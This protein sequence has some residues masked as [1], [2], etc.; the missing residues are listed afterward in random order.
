MGM[1]AHNKIINALYDHIGNQAAWRNSL[2]DYLSLMGATTYSVGLCDDLGDMF[3]YIA[4]PASMDLAVGREP[5]MLTNNVSENYLANYHHYFAEGDPIAQNTVTM[6]RGQQEG[7]AVNI[8]TDLRK[9][10]IFEELA[11][12]NGLGSVLNVWSDNKMN[13]ARKIQ[14]AFFRE[15]VEQPFTQK[16]IAL[17]KD[18]IDHLKRAV[19]LHCQAVE[20]QSRIAKLESIM[21]AWQT[22][23]LFCNTQGRLLHA[24]A[25]GRKLLNDN[26]YPVL[27]HFLGSGI[28][29]AKDA[30]QLQQGFSNAL[31]GISSCAAF[32]AEN[33][34]ESSGIIIVAL[35]IQPLNN[36]G[37]F[38][39]QNGVVYI[40][41]E[42]QLSAD[43][44]V[45]LAVQAYKLSGAEAKLLHALVKG[46]TPSEFANAR[47]VKI[48]TV[49]SQI[50]QLLAKTKTRRQQDLLALIS[51]M[52]GL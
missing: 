45:N 3:Q 21:D 32:P 52:M 15:N 6:T 30:E 14:L 35:G 37:L 43:S 17:V 13:D 47:G 1:L 28:K 20:L 33:G 34:S 18:D 9:F 50:S 11:I 27:H 5:V 39:T 44:A 31:S 19:Y 4:D 41:L 46:M 2:E 38:T 51:R 7:V 40:V 42:R 36:F 29:H 16:H 23:L 8:N 26:E 25:R 22:G 12:P 49:R 24:N 10:K 48:S